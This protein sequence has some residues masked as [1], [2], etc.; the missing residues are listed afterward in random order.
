LPLQN[1][2]VIPHGDVTKPNTGWHGSVRD[3]ETRHGI[4]SDPRAVFVTVDEPAA[5]TPSH[6]P[7]TPPPTEGPVAF[8]IATIVVTILVMIAMIGGNVFAVIRYEADKKK[9]GAPASRRALGAWAHSRRGC[10]RERG[11]LGF[12]RLGRG[13]HRASRDVGVVAPC[14][15][16][17]VASLPSSGTTCSRA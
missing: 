4:R 17:P 5:W 10:D 14:P 9:Q 15:T 13:R 6:A 1:A 8:V 16:A 7:P 3:A 12:A 11:G 2:K